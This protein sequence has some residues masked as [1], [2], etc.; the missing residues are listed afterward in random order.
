MPHRPKHKPE[1]EATCPEGREP[2]ALETPLRQGGAEGTEEHRLRAD[3]GQ[4]QLFFKALQRSA[5]GGPC[6]TGGWSPALGEALEPTPQAL[7]ENDLTQDS[8][9]QAMRQ[10][11][12]ATTARHV[13][14]H[15]FSLPESRP[16]SEQ[17]R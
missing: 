5:S 16:T 10:G 14:R 11:E 4:S 17:P 13:P 6:G 8:V 9:P 12:T 1:E 7:M 3:A 15:K 2:P